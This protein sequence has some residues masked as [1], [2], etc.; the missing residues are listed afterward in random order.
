[1]VRDICQIG[2]SKGIRLTKDMLQHLGVDS[3][4]EVTFEKGKIV[5][6]AP[7]KRQSFEDAVQST[8][9]QYDGALKEL[10]EAP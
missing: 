5:L 3:Q 4:V 8:F 2:N 9:K 10:S 7:R 1:M 6:T